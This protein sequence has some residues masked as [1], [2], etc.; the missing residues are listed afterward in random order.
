MQTWVSKLFIGLIVAAALLLAL[1]TAPANAKSLEDYDWIEVETEHFRL[2]SIRGKRATLKY[3]RELTL[4]IN[5]MPEEIRQL[6]SAGA[7]FVTI[8]LLRDTGQLEELIYGDRPWHRAN[9]AV[10]WD[11]GNQTIALALFTDVRSNLDYMYA[12]YIFG[13]GDSRLFGSD[14]MLHWW[15]EGL[16][17]YYRQTGIRRGE[18]Y[19]GS[20]SPRVMQSE[21]ELLEIFDLILQ[22]ASRI[23]LAQDDQRAFIYYS[24]RLLRFL[25]DNKESWEDL[26]NRLR[27]Y[28]QLVGNDV[29]YQSAFEEAFDMTMQELA[30]GMS[31]HGQRCCSRYKVDLEVIEKDFDPEVRKLD[32][33]TIKEALEEISER[34][35]ALRPDE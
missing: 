27:R 23:G 14:E 8:Y 21:A 2:R 7:G 1:P 13:G 31:E 12:R 28:V 24:H 5:V 35:R 9:P 32:R 30:A 3:A 11:R 17:E 34:R 18:Y 10:S 6:T 26:A 29:D 33:D 25:M 20:S 22:P 15:Q 19:Y 16:V 4:V